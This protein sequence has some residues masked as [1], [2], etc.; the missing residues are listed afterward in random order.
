MYGIAIMD[1][2]RP[3]SPRG[4]RLQRL[5]Q[6]YFDLLLRTVLSV[7]QNGLISIHATIIR[8]RH[9]LGIS[10]ASFLSACHVLIPTREA[11]AR[12]NDR[13]ASGMTLSPGEPRLVRDYSTA[14]RAPD[15]ARLSVNHDSGA[16][17][18][19]PTVEIEA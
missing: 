11:N 4:N 14:L 1:E 19:L 9:W 5:R 8:Y 7:P 16:K 3:V 12:G 13:S 10:L 2:S 6:S 18:T 15:A 17:V